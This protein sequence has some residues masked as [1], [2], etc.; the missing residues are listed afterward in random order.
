MY[1][2]HVTS[3]PNDRVDVVVASSLESA[4][5]T[6]KDQENGRDG[7]RKVTAIGRGIEVDMIEPKL[8]QKGH[9]YRGGA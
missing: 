9:P 5:A 8:L 4:L 1:V 7:S 6:F 3:M 2:W